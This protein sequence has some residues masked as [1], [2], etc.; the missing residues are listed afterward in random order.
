[1]GGT[2][3]WGKKTPQRGKCEMN[4]AGFK[5]LDKWKGR[6]KQRPVVGHDVVSKAKKEEIWI[7]SV[8]R[9]R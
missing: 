7:Y 9:R 4:L 8:V 6:R 5:N 2:T 1:M 3:F